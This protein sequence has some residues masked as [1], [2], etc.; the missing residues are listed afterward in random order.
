[1]M[2]NAGA[3]PDRIRAAIPAIIERAQEGY[4]LS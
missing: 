4:F 3:E 2:L 1:M